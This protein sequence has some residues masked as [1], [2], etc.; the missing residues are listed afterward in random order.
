M[1]TKDKV[2]IEHLDDW[3]KA[4]GN[5][6]RRGEI[7]A[8][9]V[10]VTKCHPK[11]V[12]RT[13]RRI[14]LK[15][16][17]HQDKRGRNL[18]YDHTVIAALRDVWK[19]SDRACGELLHPLI[20]EYVVVL[21]R[22]G[23]KNDNMCV[24]ERNGHVIRRYLGWER[25]DALETLPFVSE[26]C[27]TVTLYVNH[28]KAVRRMTSKERIG[29]KYKRVYEKRATTPYERVLA[30]EDISEDAKEKLREKHG[31]LNPLSLLKKIAKFKK[32]I[33]ELTKAARNRT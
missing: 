2:F 26:L 16:R 24:E 27:D 5:R 6:K 31:I 21:Q 23:Q 1:N 29:A 32:K 3:L 8:H 20:K 18:Y 12:S 11:S 15:D 4:K 33:Y 9:I 13:F 22:D 10:F 25:L 19:A 17:T 14:Q 28:W 30:R 7:S